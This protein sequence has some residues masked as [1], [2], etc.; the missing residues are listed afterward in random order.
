MA[1]HSSHLYLMMPSDAAGQRLQQL[2]YSLYFPRQATEL[3][4]E[5]VAGLAGYSCT[6]RG[7][8]LVKGK[9]AL[10]TYWITKR[11]NGV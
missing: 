1:S 11:V 6:F 10:P 5:S 8:I 3:V 7:K 9:G 4:A 2:V